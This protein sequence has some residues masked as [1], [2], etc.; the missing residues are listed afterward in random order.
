MVKIPHVLERVEIPQGVSVEVEGL[1]VTV[2]GPKGTLTKD[3]SH[4]KDVS[5]RVEEGSVIVET[6]MVNRRKK[7]L[8]GTAAAHIRNMIKGVT[9]GY[10]YKLKIVFSHFPISVSVDEKNKRVVIK[11]FLGERSDRFAKIYGDV[12]VKVQGNDIIVEGIDI[13]A[14][15]LTAASIER[16]T[17]IK[18]LDRRVFM[19]GIYIYEKGEAVD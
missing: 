4:M 16:A 18:D 10:R 15:G 1:K 2:K 12:K 17:K 7:A 19:D 13:E 5:I 6:Y 8:V 11:N 9:V 14:V 3:F